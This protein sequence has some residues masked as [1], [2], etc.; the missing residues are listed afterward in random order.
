M[1]PL[2]L[3]Y[4]P[5]APPAS[6]A[7]L[8]LDATHAV[9]TAASLVVAPLTLDD[10]LMS[11][12]KWRPPLSVEV[13]FELLDGIAMELQLA[14]YGEIRAFRLAPGVP[15]AP[16][17]SG[18]EAALQPERVPIQVQGED[19]D[20]CYRRLSSLVD[21]YTYSVIIGRARHSLKECGEQRVT[22][23]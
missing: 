16:A 8:P 10:H 17:A 6:L 9:Q 4:A 11:N 13:V 2:C 19:Q 23:A 7:G 3:D 15:M 20:G 14:G 18:S 21:S 5:P 12:A 1:T 22:I